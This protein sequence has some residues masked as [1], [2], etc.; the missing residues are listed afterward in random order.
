MTSVIQP[1]R[2]ILDLVF[3][4]V[5]D[6]K[7]ATWK[8]GESFSSTCIGWKS[9]LSSAKFGIVNIAAASSRTSSQDKIDEKKAGQ[10]LARSF[11][12]SW[13]VFFGIHSDWSWMGS[14]W[15]E[16]FLVRLAL[17]VD[18]VPMS[19]QE[20]TICLDQIWIQCGRKCGELDTIRLKWKAEEGE[21]NVRLFRVE[22]DLSLE[23]FLTVLAISGK[24][25]MGS[26][27]TRFAKVFTFDWL[28]SNYY[29]ARWYSPNVAV[30]RKVGPKARSDASIAR[31][32]HFVSPAR[33]LV[34]WCCGWPA[35]LRRSLSTLLAPKTERNHRR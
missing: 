35:L 14:P 28:L 27:W 31:A 25:C 3:F 22:T 8:A 20:R 34:C 7:G 19:R 13:K 6:A 23:R 5:K 32:L 24:P 1:R 16:N 12:N 18:W 15:T 10:K 11:A 26:A 4:P 2:W 29:G 30:N 17:V 33:W 9:E 21:R